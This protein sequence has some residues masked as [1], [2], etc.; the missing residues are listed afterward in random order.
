VTLPEFLE[1]P[2]LAECVECESLFEPEFMV[3]LGGDHACPECFDLY[4]DEDPDGLVGDTGLEEDPWV[5]P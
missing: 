4:Y 2:H 5:Q 1:P 3:P